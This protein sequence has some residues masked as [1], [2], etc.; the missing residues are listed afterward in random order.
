MPARP[1]AAAI[2]LHATEM[3]DSTVASS[4]STLPLRSSLKSQVLK[5]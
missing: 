4:V 3:E 2:C 5:V 1:T